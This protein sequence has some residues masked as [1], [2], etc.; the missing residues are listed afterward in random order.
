[1]LAPEA[2]GASVE[3]KT[4]P[5]LRSRTRDTERGPSAFQETQIPVEVATRGER[6]FSRDRGWFMRGMIHEIL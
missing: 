3:M 4:P 5:V 1:M 6:R 2:A